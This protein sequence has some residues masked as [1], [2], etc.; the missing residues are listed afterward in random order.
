MLRYIATW[1]VAKEINVIPILRKGHV[2]MNPD[3]AK[4]LHTTHFSYQKPQGITIA[5]IFT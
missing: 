4:G 2:P 3:Y 5:N 1:S